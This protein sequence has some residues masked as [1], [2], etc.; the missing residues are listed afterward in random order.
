MPDCPSNRKGDA[1]R[2]LRQTIERQGVVSLMFCVMNC[3]EEVGQGEL[4]PDANVRQLLAACRHSMAMA[5][6]I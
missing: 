4:D 6:Q 5:H 1:S 3:D 2:S